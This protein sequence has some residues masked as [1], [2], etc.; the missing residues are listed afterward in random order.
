[1]TGPSFDPE[2]LEQHEASDPVAEQLERYAQAT[3]T[4]PPSGLTDRIMSAIADEP[5]PRRTLGVWLA[6]LLA[7]RVPGHRVAR[8]GV[9]A[10]AVALVLVG[11]FAFGELGRIINDS[12][13]GNTPSPAIETT[14]PTTSPT[15]APT[16]SPSSNAPEI[17]P[18]EHESGGTAASETADP[19]S[20]SGETAA[21]TP[22]ASNR[23]GG[24]GGSETPEPTET[25]RASGSG[26]GDT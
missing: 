2:Q 5:T 12:N 10:A 24:H 23:E 19:T 13:V 6:G 21:P 15:E 9:L 7:G 1:M 8:A 18:G 26:G 3:R 16:E 17:T 22:P 25:P 11:A 20:T 4:A 14:V